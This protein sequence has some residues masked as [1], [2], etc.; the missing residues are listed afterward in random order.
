MCIFE[1]GKDFFT[2]KDE[3][4]TPKYPETRKSCCAKSETQIQ[5][6][7]KPRTNQFDQKMPPQKDSSHN[8][9]ELNTANR[10]IRHFNCNANI[11]IAMQ[12]WVFGLFFSLFHPLDEER[13][14]RIGKTFIFLKRRSK[15]T[16]GE[17]FENARNHLHFYGPACVCD[18]VCIAM[19][20]A[21][22]CSVCFSMLQCALQCVAVS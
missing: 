2:K 20:V 15:Q 11:V 1:K 18:A 19:C 12:T 17:T 8:R 14:M 4:S 9:T 5:I 21:V 7:V 10:E 22:C 3:S 16:Y 6:R 13:F